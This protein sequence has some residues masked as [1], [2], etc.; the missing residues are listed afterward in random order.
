MKAKGW[1]AIALAAVVAGGGTSMLA[2][3]MTEKQDTSVSTNSSVSEETEP[4]QEI[5]KQLEERKM[6]I[7]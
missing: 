7:E 6:E 4:V 3:A 5:T 2:G 1:M